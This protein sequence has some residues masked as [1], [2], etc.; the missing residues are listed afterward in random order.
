MEGATPSPLGVAAGLV[1][2]VFLVAGIF[3]N[4]RRWWRRPRWSAFE[5]AMQVEARFWC[6]RDLAALLCL[7]GLLLGLGALSLTLLNRLPIWLSP[8]RLRALMVFQNLAVHGGVLVWVCWRL[9]RQSTSWR[10]AFEP[11]AR[12]QPGVVVREAVCM[13]LM[14]LPYVVA[15][16]LLMAGVLPLLGIEV[17]SQPILSGFTDDVAPWWFRGW[18]I[19]AAVV[20]APIVEEIVFRGVFMP[21]LMRSLGRYG[22]LLFVSVFFA[23]IHGHGPSFLPLFVIGLGFGVAYLHTASLRVAIGM[24]AIFNGVNVLLLLSGVVDRAGL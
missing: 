23:L 15:S 11:L 8:N 22:A 19:L 12:R 7:L 3:I 4:L 20:V 21:A 5:H 1:V 9:R 17:S 10:Q 24:H 6:G 13:Y 16:S 14:F 2:L 18:L